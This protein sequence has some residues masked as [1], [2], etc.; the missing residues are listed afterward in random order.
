VD[1]SGNFVLKTYNEGDGAP[2]GSYRVYLVHDP[3][4]QTPTHPGLYDAA[5]TTPLTATIAEEANELALELKSNA[6]PAASPGT[7]PGPGGFDP[8]AAY[9]TVRGPG[10][11]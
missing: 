5:N 4:T 2:A 9:Q 6:G 1:A 10:A 7:A 11:K 3:L 8:F